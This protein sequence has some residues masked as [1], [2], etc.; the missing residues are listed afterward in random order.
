MDQEIKLDSVAL[1]LG[2]VQGRHDYTQGRVFLGREGQRLA[3]REEEGAVQPTTAVQIP[4]M[5][6]PETLNSTILGI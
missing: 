3:S 1:Y 2:Y 5:V 4:D 6:G